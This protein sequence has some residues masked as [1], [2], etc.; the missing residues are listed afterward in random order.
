MHWRILARPQSVTTSV[1][2]KTCWHDPANCILLKKRAQRLDSPVSTGNLLEATG[3][4]SLEIVGLFSKM[5]SY[6]QEVGRENQRRHSS[7]GKEEQ[8]P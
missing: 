6:A 4:H 8:W 2:V 1:Q 5:Q 7:K 3:S